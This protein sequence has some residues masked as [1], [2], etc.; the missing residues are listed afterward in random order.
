MINKYIFI[1]VFFL[2]LLIISCKDVP[3]VIPGLTKSKVVLNTDPDSA[4]ILFN[5]QVAANVSPFIISDLEPGFYRFDLNRIHYLDTTIYYLLKRNVEDSIYV[6]LRED[7]KYWW[8]TYNTKNSTLPTNSLSKIRIDKFDNKWIGTLYNGLVKFDGNTFTVY[9]TSNSGIPGNAINDFYFTDNIIWVATDHGIG[10]FDGSSWKVYNISNSQIPSE[11]ITALTFDHN[12]NL[13]VGTQSGLL[14]F[15]GVTFTTFNRANSGIS[16][17]NI[18]ALAVDQN[19]ALWI[20]SWGNG[21]CKLDNL[22]WSIYS[23]YNSQL[24]DNYIS[25]IK[26]DNT[27]MIWA[28]TGS[29]SKNDLGTGGVSYFNNST[30]NNINRFNSGFQGKI[31][32]DLSFDLINNIWISTDTG[33]L[34]YDGKKWNFYTTSNSGLPDNSVVSVSIDFH[35]NKWV[36]SIGL[37]EYIGGK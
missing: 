32:T 28:S 35:Q 22:T 18:S 5:S 20:G 15:D 19:N 21:I 13:W 33:F 23:T 26:L 7:P 14:K 30:W 11:Y 31:A 16:S 12:N 34:K 37:S 8:K 25:S 4:S 24:S 1:T 9:N 36:T 27:G 29:P 3:P 2:P 6:V 10:R 17:D